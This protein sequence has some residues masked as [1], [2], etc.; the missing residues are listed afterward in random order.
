MSGTGK[1][2]ALTGTLAAALTVGGCG[3][4]ASNAPNTLPDSWYA[5][6]EC[7]EYMLSRGAGTS[8]PD[9]CLRPKTM[10]VDLL[11]T[12]G[13]ERQY[14]KGVAEGVCEAFR[15]GTYDTPPAPYACK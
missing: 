6:L 1:V 8:A 2:L 12:D 15:N 11:G 14:R 4:S 5:G 13:D 7:V 10:D 9:V 3:G